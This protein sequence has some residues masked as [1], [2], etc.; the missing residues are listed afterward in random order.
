[1]SEPFDGA[2]ERSPAPSVSLR[3]VT[4]RY[5][6]VTACRGVD[7]ELRPGRIHGILGENGAGKS[8][9]MKIMIGLVHPD[10]GSVWVGGREVYIADPMTAADLGIAMVHQHYSLVE[11]LSVWENITL[12]DPRRLDRD[13]ARRRVVELG[14]RYGLVVDPDASVSSLTAGQRQ[15]VE[16]IKCLRREPSII[17]FD[18]PTS[19]LTPQESQQL[20][21]VLRRVV[22]EEGRAV[23]LVSHKLEEILHATDEVTIMR[24][25]EVVDRRETA[26]ATAAGLAQA[27]VGRPVSLRAEAAALGLV[28]AVAESAREASDDSEAVATVP[29]ALVVRDLVVTASDGRRLLDGL[30]IEVR[31]G[32]IV[33]LAG[34]E[35]NGQRALADVLSS[36]LAADGGTIEVAGSLVMTGRAGV[37]SQ[38]GVGVI[39]EDRHD[40]GCVLDLSVAENLLLC[41]PDLVSRNGIM[42]RSAMVSRARQL[43]DEFEIQAGS[44]SAPM[45]S[46]SGGNQ[47]RV[48]LARELS[49]KPVVLV[50]A[51]PTRGL[52]VGAIEYMGRRLQDAAESGVAVLL[53]STELEEILALAHRICVIHSGRI[54]GSMPRRQADPERLGL[55]IGGVA[56]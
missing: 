29:P 51:Q 36:L 18:E 24:A 53:I 2:G 32:E 9:L 52:D 47:Q 20:F 17:V 41:H 43:M 42:D 48:V 1:M 31:P 11:A 30:S 4:K 37:M 56:S 21:A 46:L 49:A 45:R 16:I 13:A 54:V 28:S 40:S 50:A 22:A 10:S 26:E 25:G 3:A 15:R 55:L 27:M 19:V 34:V 5:G 14:E 44:P 7:L 39:P 38:A 35:G 6:A 8:T 23:A 33:G 12:G